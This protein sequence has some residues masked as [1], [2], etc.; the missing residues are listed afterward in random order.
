MKLQLALDTLPLGAAI[1]LCRDVVDLVDIVEIGTPLMMRE[2]IH[3]VRAFRDAFPEAKI[4]ADTKIMDGG[5]LES[6]LMFA[7]G[8]NYVTVLGVADPA[9]LA[10]CVDAARAAGGRVVADLLCVDDLAARGPELVALG[11]D[12]LAVHT[13]TDQQASGRT[14]LGDLRTLRA[15]LP[16]ADLAV[17]GG[18]SAATI[19]AYVAER[20]AIVICGS[21]ICDAPDPREQAILIG[22]A[23]HA[24]PD[25]GAPA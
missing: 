18:I 6:T 9:T 25:R 11:V 5:H 15:A 21:A 17:A 12:V 8:A 23:V 16:D 7:A 22:R 14:P 10:A 24:D 1:A 3:A 4:L 19:A 2:G 13:G 20:P